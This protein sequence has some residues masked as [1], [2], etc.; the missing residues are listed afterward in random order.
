MKK[1]ADGSLTLY[2]LPAPNGDIHLVMRLY[3]PK[4][5][6]PSVLPPGEGAWKPP[7]IAV[8]QQRSRRQIDEP[9]TLSDLLSD[10]L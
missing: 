2:W 10:L 3:R 5:E 9:D 1:N 7:V 6:A 8:A 4:T